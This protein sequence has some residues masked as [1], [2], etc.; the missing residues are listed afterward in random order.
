MENKNSVLNFFRE[1]QSFDWLTKTTKTIPYQID[2]L[3]SY[4]NPVR[5]AY[6]FIVDN[7]VYAYLSQLTGKAQSELL[8]SLI[9]KQVGFIIFSKDVPTIATFIKQNKI[10][11]LQSSLTGDELFDTIGE[12]LSSELQPSE[13]KQGGLLIVNSQGLLITGRTGAGKSQLLL[14]LLDRGHQWVSEELTHCFY[15][16]H[17][18]LMGKAVNELPSFAH[19]KHI[20]PVNIDQTFGLSK[21]IKSYPLAAIIHLGENNP[22]EAFKLPVYEQQLKQSILGKTLPLWIINP[23]YPKTEILIETC[24]N[25]LIL[26]QWGK[27]ASTEM[28]QELKSHLTEPA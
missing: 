21:R 24:A 8:D 23:N 6:I 26:S 7:Q 12:N 25:Q 18:K 3:I 28:A 13:I 9:E 27:S 5:P 15:N 1:H 10:H 11:V 4:F 17:G 20:G 22:E 14:S 19:I 2:T 16:H